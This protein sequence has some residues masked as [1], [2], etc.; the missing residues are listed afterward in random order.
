MAR[1]SFGEKGLAGT[2]AQLLNT[3]ATYGEL[4][5]SRVYL[6][7]LDM[8]DLGQIDLIGAEVLRLLP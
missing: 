8:D 4:G 7:L 6:Q 1:D 2:P 5:A 3:I